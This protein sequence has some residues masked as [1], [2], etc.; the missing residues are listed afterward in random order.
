MEHLFL[1]LVWMPVDRPELLEENVPPRKK[2]PLKIRRNRVFH[3][4]NSPPTKKDK[5]RRSHLAEHGY[6]IDQGHSL[7]SKGIHPPPNRMF[8]QIG[9]LPQGKGAEKIWER[10]G[11]LPY[12]GRGDQNDKITKKNLL[13]WGFYIIYSVYVYLFKMV[14]IQRNSNR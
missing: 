5:H 2:N 4:G 11:H 1:P 7:T 8:S 10:C 13:V 3:E 14:N 9:W 12:Q 6:D